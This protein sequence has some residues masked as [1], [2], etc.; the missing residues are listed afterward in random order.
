MD[1]L[2]QSSR[3]RVDHDPLAHPRIDVTAALFL[4]VNFNA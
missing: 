1:A 4:G 3:D 2:L